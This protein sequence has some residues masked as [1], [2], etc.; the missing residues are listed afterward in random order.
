MSSRHA[1]GGATHCNFTSYYQRMRRFGLLTVA[2]F[3]LALAGCTSAPATHQASEHAQSSHHSSAAAEPTPSATPTPTPPPESALVQTI[4]QKFPGYPLIVPVSS[5][6]FRVANAFQSVTQV[7]A[8]A[9]GVYTAY[10]PASSDPDVYLDQ[11]P[12]VDG[13]CMMIKTF[14]SDRG[15]SCWNGVNRGSAEPAA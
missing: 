5:L 11:A 15:S 8:L 2:A 12:S 14:F 4:K 3:A 7:V 6:D 9:P 1:F 10:G 13:D